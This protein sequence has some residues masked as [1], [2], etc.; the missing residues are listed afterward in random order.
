ME[1][2]ENNSTEIVSTSISQE[3]SI[4]IRESIAE[5]FLRTMSGSPKEIQNEE[6]LKK[7]IAENIG[8][9]Q[10]IG[11]DVRSVSW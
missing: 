8:L 6:I 4:E 3:L 2:L 10:K 1:E 5:T 9:L 11:V 7:Q